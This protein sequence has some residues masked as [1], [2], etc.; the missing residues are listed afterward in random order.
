MEVMVPQNCSRCKRT[1]TRTVPHDK[2]ADLVQV[3]V[4]LQAQQAKIEAFFTSLDGEPLP[5]LVVVFQG[6]VRTINRVCEACIKT[7]TSQLSTAF[8]E[9]DVTKRTRTVKKKGA[10][11]VQEPASS[12][13]SNKK[14]KGEQKTA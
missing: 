2:V 8:K 1:T 11:E 4:H 3:D 5:D 9:I 10:I 6:K 13:S 14:T 7:L 12:S